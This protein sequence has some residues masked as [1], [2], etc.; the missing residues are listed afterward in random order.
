MHTVARRA[1]LS[2]QTQIVPPKLYI[3]TTETLIVTDAEFEDPEVDLDGIVDIDAADTGIEKKKLQAIKEKLR[4]KLPGS[5]C[6]RIR[7][8]HH[9][10]SEAGS[11]NHQPGHEHDSRTCSSLQSML[12]HPS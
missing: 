2:K 8:P 11:C 5:S 10:S 12:R 6:R 9:N 4:H 7:L 1:C 3:Q